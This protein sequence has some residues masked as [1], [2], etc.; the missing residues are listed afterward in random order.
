MYRP[1]VS[2]TIE[3]FLAHPVPTTVQD[4]FQMVTV[5]DLLTMHWLLKSAPN[6]SNTWDLDQLSQMAILV[7][8]LN[9]VRNVHLQEGH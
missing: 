7:G 6:L 3:Q 2:S 8:R 5:F 1:L 4:L 9:V